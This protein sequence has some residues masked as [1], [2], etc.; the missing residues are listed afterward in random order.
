MIID[1]RSDTVTKP[2]PGM[3][4]AMMRAKVGDDVF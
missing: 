1:F 3:M 4:E 2:T